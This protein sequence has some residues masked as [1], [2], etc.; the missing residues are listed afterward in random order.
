MSRRWF[1]SLCACSG[2]TTSRRTP[3]ALPVEHVTTADAS[4]RRCLHRG[5]AGRRDR[6]GRLVQLRNGLGRRHRPR[7]GWLR[8]RSSATTCT[9][10]SHRGLGV[11]SQ[12][13]R[14]AADYLAADHAAGR[15]PDIASCAGDGDEQT[16][17]LLDTLAGTV[18]T[19]GDTVY[20]DGSPA[21]S[22]AAPPPSWGRHPRPHPARPWATTSTRPPAPAATAGGSSATGWPARQGLV[23]LRPGTLASDRA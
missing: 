3:S 23:Q 19:L 8:A 9:A 21:N 10:E 18:L 2:R 1:P 16:A 20:D 7:A 4:G 14:W 6:V 11:A 17:A 15:R 22:R 12:R 5:L 13:G